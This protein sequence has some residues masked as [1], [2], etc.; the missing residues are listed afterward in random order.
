VGYVRPERAHLVH[1]NEMDG[2]PD[3]AVEIISRDS[4][5]RDYGEKRGLYQDA[6]VT[7][8]WIIDP[9]QSRVEF[10]TLHEGCYRFVPLENNRIFR[11]GVIPAFWLDVNWLLSTPL[12]SATLSRTNI[13][14]ATK[15]RTASGNM[16]TNP[17]QTSCSGIG[18]RFMLP[19]LLSLP[20]D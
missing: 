4:R 5:Q 1:D 9:L 8:Y 14:R 19:R 20:T 18:R 13:G 17:P 16:N 3:I 6:G 7:E 11:C 15:G 2:G 10:L 12:P